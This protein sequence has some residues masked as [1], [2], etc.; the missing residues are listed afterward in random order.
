MA[1]GDFL[2]GEKFRNLVLLVCSMLTVFLTYLA[3]Q[4]TQWNFT[5]IFYIILASTYLFLSVLIGLPIIRNY[6]LKDDILKQTKINLEL[7]NI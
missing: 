6:Y 2:F 3:S 5:K 4:I 7:K 1:Y